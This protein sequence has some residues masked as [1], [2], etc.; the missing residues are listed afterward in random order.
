[1][2]LQ[3][4]VH[5]GHMAWPLTKEK[6]EEEEEEEVLCVCQSGCCSRSWGLQ[7]PPITLP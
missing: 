3:A 4:A 1:M 5:L 2:G 7:G 6:E